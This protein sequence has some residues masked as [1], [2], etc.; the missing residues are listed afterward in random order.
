MK[1]LCQRSS[2]DSLHSVLAAT[3]KVGVMA[4]ADDTPLV[5]GGSSVY[6]GCGGAILGGAKE[7]TA[8]ALRCVGCHVWWHPICGG[9]ESNDFTE[10]KKNLAGVNFICHA[11]MDSVNGV[12]PEPVRGANGVYRR[13]ALDQGS[14]RPFDAAHV[15]AMTED[16]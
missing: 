6:Y 2:A 4:T 15:A 9:F 16:M 14:V 11:C 7:N 12:E 8:H 3:G 10:L 13:Q 1:E 5:C